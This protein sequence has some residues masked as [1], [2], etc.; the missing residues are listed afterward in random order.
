MQRKFQLVVEGFGTSHYVG[1]VFTTFCRPDTGYD[2]F[3][4]VELI[5]PV[6]QTV[7]GTPLV[8]KILES[9]QS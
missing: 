8:M 3:M 5:I 2:K 6:Q 1:P 7:P 4:V 9:P